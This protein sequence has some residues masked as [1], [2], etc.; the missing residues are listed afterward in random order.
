MPGL[1][2]RVARLE[3]STDGLL[4]GREERV[5]DLDAAE[6][7]VSA[8]LAAVDSCRTQ[9]ERY[10]EKVLVPVD[11]WSALERL[12]D[13]FGLLRRDVEAGPAA[14]CRWAGALRSSCEGRACSSMCCGSPRPRRTGWRRET[15]CAACSRAYQAKAQAV[16]LAES[17]EL[18]ELYAAARDVL[19][20]APCDLELAERRLALFQRAIR[21]G[22]GAS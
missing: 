16:G 2:A 19:Y 11:T 13:E 6:A 3:D 20:S 7:G 1:Q 4:R 17:L 15:S 10:A 5:Q 21:P 14:G 18:A 22:P 8:G 12:A 9:L